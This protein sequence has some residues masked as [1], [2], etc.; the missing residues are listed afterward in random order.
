M[1][2]S[3]LAGMFAAA[4]IAG[5]FS[6]TASVAVGAQ[7][8][9]TSSGFSCELDAAIAAGTATQAQFAEAVA[10]LPRDPRNPDVVLLDNGVRAS[11]REI[12]AIAAAGNG[13]PAGN[14]ASAPDR[15]NPANFV[16][17]LQFSNNQRAMSHSDFMYAVF[18]GVST[19]LFGTVDLC[20]PPPVPQNIVTQAMLGPVIQPSQ[21]PV[22]QSPTTNNPAAFSAAA[23]RQPMR[24]YACELV[25][26]VSSGT[27]T[28]AQFAQAVARLP[29]D[30]SNPDIVL[31][32]DGVR[33]RASQI[34]AIAA[35]GNG[36]AAAPVTSEPDRTNPDNYISHLLYR[37]GGTAIAHS[38]FIASVFSG[39]TPSGGGS[40]DLCSPAPTPA[41]QNI[42]TDVL[43]GPVVQSPVSGGV[44]PVAAPGNLNMPAGNATPTVAMTCPLDEA[45]QLGT[46]TPAQFA[47]AVAR[48]P[49]D[50]NN[51]SIV[52]LANGARA[53]L[54]AI[55]ALVAGGSGLPASPLSTP[56]DRS[57]PNNLMAYLVHDNGGNALTHQALVAA[58]FRGV[59]TSLGGSVDL[60]APAPAPRQ[61]NVSIGSPAPAPVLP[62]TPVL[63]QPQTLSIQSPTTGNPVAIAGSGVQMTHQGVSINLAC[64]LEDAI[65]LG[66][67][68][69]AQ[70][71]EAVARLPRDPSNP[72]IVLL[73]DGVRAR[74]SQIL[75]IAAAGNGI[76]AGNVTG[77]PDRTNPDNYIAYLQSFSSN[78]MPH[79]SFIGE[80]FS[81]LTTSHNG[82]V[83]LCS[84]AP[85]PA[86]PTL[87]VLQPPQPL[88]VQ[89]P[90]PNN[91]AAVAGSGANMTNF[92]VFLDSNCALD[93]A[94]GAGTATQAQLIEGVARL[95]RDPNNPDIVLL[96]NGVRAR[97]SQILSIAAAGNGIPAGNVTGMPDRTNPDNY[98]AYLQ[99]FSPNG[100]PHSAFIASVFSGLTASSGGQLNMCSP[101]PTPASHISPVVEQPNL[102]ITDDG[103]SL[104]AMP[105]VDTVSPTPTAPNAGSVDCWSFDERTGLWVQNP[106][107]PGSPAPTTEQPNL[108]IT[109]D[110]PSLSA[111][112][113]DETGSPSPTEPNADSVDCWSFDERTG[114]WVQNPNCPGSPAPTTEQP[115]LNITD[116][117]P[118]LSALPIDETGSPSPTEPNA[119]SVD[120]WSFDERTGLWVQNPNCPGSPAPIPDGTQT[121]Q[122]AGLVMEEVIDELQSDPAENIEG[123]VEEAIRE[124][125]EEAIEVCFFEEECEF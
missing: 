67:A 12:L 28:Q 36:I 74:A 26:A 33:A 87:P 103:P 48:L 125:V 88:S 90:T 25:G 96:D 78:G 16:A 58:I 108:N 20:A 109:D 71:V 98:T 52:L 21:P 3:R 38:T 72:D 60:C 41:S 62:V 13:V 102:N 66:T 77:T 10:R 56:P 14:V 55:N 53:Q 97:A 35:A 80:V 81:G 51:P 9:V 37:S 70:F 7:G 118:S 84:S 75:S 114:L 100:M 117:G 40:A 34:L 94:L 11:A 22:I 69:Q 4:V 8:L 19:G 23:T 31:L 99:S 1:K 85:T 18:S 15:A 121:V 42:V 63:Q 64:E 110:G 47:E 104:S 123:I 89:S 57:D 50:P 101:A 6:L 44:A 73:A 82:P 65:Q 105:N 119:D 79:S 68:T 39:L 112:P 107:C 5:T 111:L 30:P 46:A 91:P 43:L 122:P 2:T 32:D 49:R 24:R 116:D 29:R 120:C 92:G 27:A 59:A 124:T 115:N 45:I 95:P 83:N 76:P 61:V 93:N 17:H 86:S 106:N 113:I 54:G